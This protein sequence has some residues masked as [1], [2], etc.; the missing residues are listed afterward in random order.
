MIE[1][2]TITEMTKSVIKSIFPLSVMEEISFNDMSIIQNQIRNSVNTMTSGEKSYTILIYPP[3]GK[4]GITIQSGDYTC[5]AID[6]YLNDTIIDF[7]L[8]YLEYEVLT[9]EQRQRTFMFSQFFYNSLTNTKLLGTS[10]DG[11]L[12]AAQKRHKRV[13]NW[14]KNVNI[15]EKDFIII[16]INQQSHWFL[17]IVCFPTLK[18]PV[19]MVGNQPV[20]LKSTAATAAAKKKAAATAAAIASAANTPTN[21]KNSIANVT[22]IGSTTIMPVSKKEPE[23]IERIYD[24]ESERDEAEGDESDLESAESEA[25]TTEAQPTTQPIKQ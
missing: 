24:E 11:K 8:K 20:K 2:D 15:F 10:N 22:V 21:K 6:Q 7:Y 4:G 12:T 9:T 17:A 23:N 16:P 14:T 18:G 19:T 25:E 5:L 3:T 13:K 1:A